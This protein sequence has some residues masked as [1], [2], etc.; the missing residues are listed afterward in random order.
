M[1]WKGVPRGIP[2]KNGKGGQSLFYGRD[3]K[4]IVPLRN[5][6]GWNMHATAHT[7]AK[8]CDGTVPF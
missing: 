6:T 3:R 1:T 2:R 4:G 5:K 8:Q 7:N